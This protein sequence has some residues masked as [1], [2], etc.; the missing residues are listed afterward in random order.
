MTHPWTHWVQNLFLEVSLGSSGW[1][2]VAEPT[3]A[4]AQPLLVAQLLP[5]LFRVK[6]SPLVHVLT[7]EVQPLPVTVRV[8]VGSSRLWIEV[9][10]A[11]VEAH[12][13]PV[14]IQVK[15][16]ALLLPDGLDLQGDMVSRMMSEVLVE[17]RRRRQ[18]FV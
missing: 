2:S 3:L 11:P 10:P 16:S 4:V 5:V 7:L 15:E 13:I 8:S 12:L 14:T 6:D 17:V 9:V 18:C 1:Y